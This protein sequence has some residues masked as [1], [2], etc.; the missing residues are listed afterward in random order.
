LE[1]STRA[2][3]LKKNMNKKYSWN[4]GYHLKEAKRSEEQAA[5]HRKK[6]MLCKAKAKD[7]AVKV[8]Q[9]ARNAFEPG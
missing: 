4:A 3:Y 9:E 5:Y 2:E 8:L 6:A 7:D 1:Q